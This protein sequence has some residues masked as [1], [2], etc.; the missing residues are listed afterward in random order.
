MP[1]ESAEWRPVFAR[2]SRKVQS[3]STQLSCGRHSV[4]MTLFFFFEISLSSISALTF[5]ELLSRQHEASA[6]LVQTTGATATAKLG[7]V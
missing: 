7:T 1:S 2:F 4:V 5:R 3:A 6:S